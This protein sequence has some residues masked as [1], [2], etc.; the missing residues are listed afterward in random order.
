MVSQ[1]IQHKSHYV[2]NFGCQLG[3]WI[4]VS[5]DQQ[6]KNHRLC[7]GTLDPHHGEK[8]GLLSH[9]EMEEEYVWPSVIYLGTIETPFLNCE[10]K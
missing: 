2:Y 6:Q 4:L 9:H 10:G 1:R 7:G 8:A 5:R 3:I